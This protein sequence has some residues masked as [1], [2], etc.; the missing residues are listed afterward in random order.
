MKR[1]SVARAFT[2]ACLLSSTAAIAFAGAAWAQVSPHPTTP[3]GGASSLPEGGGTI[4]GAVVDADHPGETAGLT[5]ALYALRPD[6][7]PGIASTETAGDGS[8][9]F[10]GISEDPGIVY[11]VG[12]RYQLV[13]YGERTAFVAGQREIDLALPVKRPT[14]DASAVEILETTLQ[15]EARG[16][17]LAIL[18]SHKIGNGG[19]A[20]VYVPEADRKTARPPF[21]ARLPLGALNFETGVFNAN[22]G[23]EQQGPDLSYWGPL[24]SGEQE[25]RYAYE[26]PIDSGASVVAFEKRFPLGAG[27]IRVVAPEGGP[28]VESPDLVAGD[29]VEIDGTRLALLES[30]ARDPGA[31][32]RLTVHVPETSSDRSAVSL[33]RTEL[34]IELD[35]TV[36]EVTQIQRLTVS[37]GAYV[38]GS[39]GEPL[40]RFDLPL[41]AELVGVSK[42]AEQLGIQTIETGTEKGIAVLGPLAPGDH[43]FSFRY[44]IPAENRAATLD[45]RFPLTVPTLFMRVADT[46][47]RIESDRFHRLRPQPMGSRT[48][49]LRE[50]FHVE[51]DE[52]IHVRF[53]ALDQKAPSQ[54]LGLAFVFGAS[55]FVLLFVVGPLRRAPAETAAREDA[56]R[57]G[58][59]H[60]RDLV[61]ATL[62]DLEH[63]FE[64]G[65]VA[66]EDYERGRSELRARAVELMR[67]EKQSAPA[68]RAVAAP[69]AAAVPTGRFCPSCG[70]AV[71]PSWHFCSQ[72]G[73]GLSP[74]EASGS[75]PA[76]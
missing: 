14:S 42:G 17:R 41:R 76:G 28:R 71:D 4:R 12:V 72:C 49:M 59:A 67:E 20:P 36:L 16:T 56:D 40:L 61:Y 2:L 46:G 50:A 27:R 52:R 30:G 48:W 18:E 75:E 66:A 55:A 69:P 1:G 57:S 15:I 39:H 6:G 58:L 35:D 65:K 60:E 73:G 64:T 45:L 34:S 70:G 8:F 25:L 23:F 54:L 24:Y 47:L 33:G 31:S 68:V 43:D 10:S 63:D 74:A 26:L 5:V 9:A 38:A 13:P 44:R 22:E 51:P 11:L 29:A 32:I 62:R 53:E 7:T 19:G 37:G 3:L 21:R